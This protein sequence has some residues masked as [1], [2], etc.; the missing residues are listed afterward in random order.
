[1]SPGNFE[2]AK[3]FAASKC[4][5]PNSCPSQKGILYL[6]VLESGAELPTQVEENQEQSLKQ[7]AKKRNKRGHHW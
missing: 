6:M 7:K 2:W 5:L 1:M 4:F 3:D